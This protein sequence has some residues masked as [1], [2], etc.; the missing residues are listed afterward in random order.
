M[1]IDSGH[2]STY[3]ASEPSPIHVLS[4]AKSPLIRNQTINRRIGDEELASFWRV[5]PCVQDAEMATKS[6]TQFFIHADAAMLLRFVPERIFKSWATETAGRKTSEDL[7]VI[8]SMLAL[9]S[10]MSEA[11]R[12]GGS[13]LAQVAYYAQRRTRVDTIQAVQGRLLLAAYHAAQCNIDQAAMLV[14]EAGHS[15]A[16]LE[17]NLELDQSVE[18]NRK[19]FPFGMNRIGYSEARR[20]T[21]WALFIFERLCGIVPGR[22]S[23]LKPS[24]IQLRLPMDTQSFEQQVERDMPFFKIQNIGITSSIDAAIEVHSALVKVVYLWG[25]CQQAVYSMTRH[26]DRAEAEE[27]RLQ[28]ISSRAAMFYKTLCPR[29][30]FSPPNLETACYSGNMG[31]L[32]MIN[33]LFHQTM[34]RASRYHLN[35]VRMQPKAREANLEKAVQH[36]REILAMMIQFEDIRERRRGAAV[37]PLPL[38]HASVEAA[39]IV[40]GSGKFEELRDVLNS[41]HQA[42]AG[43]EAL[44]E[45]W[46]AASDAAYAI[47]RRM[48][49]LDHIGSRGPGDASPGAGYKVWADRETKP[50]EVIMRWSLADSLDYQFPKHMD[51]VYCDF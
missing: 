35:A 23:T 6:L 39:D 12:S 50:N 4:H 30:V 43:I 19:T 25:E 26:S 32:M 49:Q 15:A 29:L 24:D 9:G 46:D 28:E 34:A 8:Y 40:S 41:L 27:E 33:A 2:T 10:V 17:L 1:K 18:A 48:N 37:T 22:P 45:I 3:I 38:V 42:R 7:M 44:N 21:F 47:G 20:R 11:S 16:S 13:Q 31:A 36:S 5:D 14:A 51:I